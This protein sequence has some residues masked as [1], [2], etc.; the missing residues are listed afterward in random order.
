M[1]IIHFDAHCDLRDDYLGVKLSHACV[2]RRCH[3][4]V[5]DGRIYQFGI[6]SGTK[7]EF[8]FAKEHTK[9]ERFRADNFDEVLALLRLSEKPVPV[10]LT[11]DL[12]VLDPRE[13]PGTGTPEAGGLSF[14]DL[15]ICLMQLGSINLVGMDF[16]ELSPPYDPSGC[17]TAL[18][19][20]ILRETLIMKYG[21]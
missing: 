2:L 13:F 20:K 21:K 3:D 8:E 12:D 4:I 11:V 16:V 18:A 10:Y 9:M 7:E 6:R 15:R 19:L 17:S 1:N 5:G 14:E